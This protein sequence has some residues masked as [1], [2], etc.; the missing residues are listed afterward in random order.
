MLKCKPRP[1][2]RKDTLARR[3]HHPDCNDAVSAMRD[4]FKK[5][6]QQFNEGS[7]AAVEGGLDIGGAGTTYDD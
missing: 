1:R 7:V 4:Q 2:Q 3:A 6:L 5:Y